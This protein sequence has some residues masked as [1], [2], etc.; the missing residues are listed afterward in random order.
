MKVGGGVEKFMI[1][2]PLFVGLIVTIYL[3]GG[4]DR[5]IGAMEKFAQDAWVAVRTAM[6]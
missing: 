2:L 3:L 5:A 6:R 1:G 4:P